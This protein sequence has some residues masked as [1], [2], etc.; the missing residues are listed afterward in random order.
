MG[1]A[2]GY[3][4]TWN[5][6]GHNRM[7]YSEC[8]QT[9]NHVSRENHH[10]YRWY[11]VTQSWLVSLW[12]CWPPT[13]SWGVQPSMFLVPYF[14]PKWNV[15]SNTSIGTMD[16]QVF[17]RTFEEFF[18][19]WLPKICLS[20]CWLHT[21]C[22]QSSTFQRIPKF[23][24]HQILLLHISPTFFPDP[25]CS[26]ISDIRRSKSILLHHIYP[27]FSKILRSPRISEGS[28]RFSILESL[29]HPNRSQKSTKNFTVTSEE[30]VQ[31][32][33]I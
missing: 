2:W 14:Q 21:P 5:M 11:C 16:L 17:L 27:Y 29:C 9:I 25:N 3:H 24:E 12:Q 7:E 8:G 18:A 22:G 28:L 4:W 30:F 26:D 1:I 20:Y 10:F 31:S 6:H 32:K 13:F 33:S 23:V 19:G 15:R